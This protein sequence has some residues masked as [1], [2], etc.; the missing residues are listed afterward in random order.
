MSPSPSPHDLLHHLT[1]ALSGV[2]SRFTRARRWSPCSVIV[3]VMLLTR[4]DLRSSYATVLTDLAQ[5]A[6]RALGVMAA[7]STS[8][9]SVARPLVPV[10]EA[11]FAEPNPASIKAALARE[12]WIA[13]ESLPP[14]W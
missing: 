10:I 11:M 14:R 12:G 13:N 5:E 1:V 8:S 6:C 7:A 2:A 3:A 9:L 4:P